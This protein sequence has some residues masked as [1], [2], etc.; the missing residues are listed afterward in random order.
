MV[1]LYY[2]LG[3]CIFFFLLLLWDFIQFLLL[4]SI[5]FQKLIISC[6]QCLFPLGLIINHGLILSELSQKPQWSIGLEQNKS[7]TQ[8][9]GVPRLVQ[10]IEESSHTQQYTDIWECLNL[11]HAPCHA[12]MLDKDLGLFW[13]WITK[14]K[15]MA[16]E[17]AEGSSL[18][19]DS[20]VSHETRNTM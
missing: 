4:Q 8:H 3:P 16:E 20:L 5:P 17:L 2:N 7:V 18:L 11:P 10:R 14:A 12:R 9:K 19:G 15:S 1:F 13:D 6:W